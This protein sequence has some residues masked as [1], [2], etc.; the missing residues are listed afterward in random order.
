MPDLVPYK[1]MTFVRL[2][3]VTEQCMQECC[4]TKQRWLWLVSSVFCTD[5]GPYRSDISSVSCSKNCSKA[6][7]KLD[8][9]D[10]LGFQ[11]CQLG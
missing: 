5:G 6:V 3:R 8:V 11:E 9:T 7:D 1:T 10:S 2:C 4:L